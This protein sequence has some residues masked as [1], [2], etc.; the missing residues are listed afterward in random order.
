MPMVTAPQKGDPIAN[1][2][3]KALT[4]RLYATIAEVFR[5]G[6]ALLDPL[7]A[8]DMVDHAAPSGPMVGREPGKQLITT[9]TRL[10]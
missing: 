4:V 9:Y 8:P 7:L 6:I 3:Y 2:N 5:T 1:E 10:S